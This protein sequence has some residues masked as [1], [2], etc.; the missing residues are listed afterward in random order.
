M[1]V[2]AL[3]AVGLLLIAQSAGA[4]SWSMINFTTTPQNVPKVAAAGDKLMSSAAGKTLTGRLVLQQHIADGND[5]AT[6]SWVPI[7]N[8]AAE[9][10]AFVQKLQADPAWPAFLATITQLSQPGST[11]MYRTIK[12]WGDVQNS[13]TVWMGHAFNVSDPAAFLAA[14]EK[15]RASPTGQKFQGQV[16]VSAVV[17][18]GISPVTHLISVGYASEAEM[19]AWADTRTPT[20]DWQDYVDASRNS[21]EYLGGSLGRDLKAWG[22]ATLKALTNPSP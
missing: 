4:A 20:K 16:H 15:F 3:A 22:P 8:S 10:E 11:V 6:H 21:A 17:A 13:D 18:G 1:R 2:I 5:P 19:E 12:S 14:L 9:R 7:Y